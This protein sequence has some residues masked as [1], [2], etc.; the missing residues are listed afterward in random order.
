MKNGR[1]AAGLFLTVWA[2]LCA[3]PK[4][5]QGEPRVSSISPMGGQQ[6]AEFEAEVR[7]VSLAGVR[8]VQF[9]T[10]GMTARVL[11]VKAE[12]PDTEVVRLAV[13]IPSGAALG[14]HAFRLITGRGIT[15]EG[16]LRVTAEPTVA[17]GAA[18]GALPVIVQGVLRQKGEMDSIW[19]EA[20][21]GETFTFQATSG[22]AGF[23]PA[24]SLWATAN[25]WFDSSRLE[26]IAV[27][28][29]P[30][31]FPG[32]STDARLVHRFEKE[33]RYCVK[34]GAFSG[35]GGPDFVY[36]LLLT[37]GVTPVPDLHPKATPQWT[38]RMFTR[39]LNQQWVDHVAVRGNAK[40]PGSLEVYKAAVEDSKE[41]PIMSP[42]G[43]VE[44][45][46]GAAAETHAIRLKIDKPQDITIE[47]QTPEATMP[48]FNL[49]VRVMQ[50]DGH[51]VVTNVHT[52]RNN[53][54]LYMMKM[55]Q[56]K[57]TVTLR[58]AGEYRLEIRDITT[59]CWAPDFA[60]RVLVRSQIPHIGKV[61]IVEE[62]V[63]IEP[64]QSKPLTVHIEREEGF[65]G[66]VAISVE[67]LPAGV[68]TMT[69]MENPIEKPPLPNAGRI[70]RYVGIPQTSS[71]ML[72]ALPEAVPSDLPVN[73]RIL[74]R[75]VVD[76]RLGEV[77]ASK[78]IPVMIIARRP[79]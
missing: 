4:K 10:P 61:N 66:Y 39:G 36:Q 26:R 38:E 58:S 47:T 8:S 68:V 32:L 12:P 37:K 79:S 64:G 30:L 24:V 18:V 41:L 34:I 16:N 59:D 7:G 52:K 17:E 9:T 60:Y 1:L 25:S 51:E 33:G 21:A 48:R 54:G 15:N 35:G 11:D 27:N 55:I 75:P 28:D 13:T 6:G 76:G 29:D 56:A 22:F 62:R 77:I 43:I 19:L 63:N 3:D 72:V 46:L 53:N 50:P 78:E 44:G 67:G 14:N 23:D 40:A 45:R 71:I 69:G 70:E 42:N 2:G 57:T 20:K 74:V 31:Y 73:A 5:P 65:K 49:I